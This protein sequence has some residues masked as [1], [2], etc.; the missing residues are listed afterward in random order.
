MHSL[1]G[2]ALI[3][4][5]LIHGTHY[6]H[7]QIKFLI[8]SDLITSDTAYSVWH[9]FSLL[10]VI[11]SI[12]CFHILK[13]IKTQKVLLCNWYPHPKESRYTSIQLLQIVSPLSFIVFFLMSQDSTV[14]EYCLS[15]SV[16]I[17][18]WTFLH[19]TIFFTP[20]TTTLHR[21]CIQEQEPINSYTSDHFLVYGVLNQSINK[22]DHQKCVT[23][24]F[25]KDA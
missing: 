19:F 3:V 14:S 22:I 24:C 17:E 1:G 18:C 25:P 11:Y 5:F 12:F 15:D 4:L 6:W 13:Q 10:I 20:F 21:F 7:R 9:V 2:S 8:V 16:E 23:S